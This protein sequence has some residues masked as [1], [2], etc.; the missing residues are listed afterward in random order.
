MCA[1]TDSSIDVALFFADELRKRELPRGGL[2][3]NQVHVTRG[4]QHDAEVE[5]GELASELAVE[6]DENT[7][8]SLMARLGMAHR[9]LRALHEA[10]RNMVRDLRGAAKKRWILPRGATSGWKCP[11]S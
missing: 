9:R 3:V 2:V 1:P 11:R 10:E 4:E 6:L 5:L 8:G 7:K